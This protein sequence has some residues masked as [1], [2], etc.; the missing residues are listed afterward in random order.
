MVDSLGPALYGATA[1]WKAAGDFKGKTGEQ[2]MRI[3]IRNW[4][5][6]IDAGYKY[7]INIRKSRAREMNTFAFITDDNI[8]DI[9][10]YVD[11]S[12]AY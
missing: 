12:K 7:A 4:H 1:R 6:P 5:D 2:W 9:M 11:S 3:W 8:S 10:L